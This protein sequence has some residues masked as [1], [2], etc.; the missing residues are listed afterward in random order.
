MVCICSHNHTNIIAIQSTQ[1]NLHYIG[2]THQNLK[3][4]VVK[5]Y[6]EIW[7]IVD[8]EYG[9]GGYRKDADDVQRNKAGLSKF[10]HSAAH[11]AKHCRTAKSNSEVKKWCED[12]IKVEKWAMVCKTCLGTSIDTVQPSKANTIMSYKV[13]EK[14]DPD[15]GKKS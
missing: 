10:A 15:A 9:D 14:F 1:S 13:E 4:A 7:K 2:S 6:N 12:N 5:H 11:F 3:R 8:E